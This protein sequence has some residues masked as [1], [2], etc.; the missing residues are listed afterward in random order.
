MT[1]LH[2]IYRAL[3]FA[4][5]VPAAGSAVSAQTTGSLTEIL[6]GN[7]GPSASEWPLYIAEQKGF[8][9]EQGLKVTII[10][11]GSSTNVANAVVTG[12]VNIATDGADAIVAAV[13]HGLTT[14]IIAPAF[15]TMPYQLIAIPSIT[16]WAQ[17]KGKSIAVGPK[18]GGVAAMAFYSMIAAQH[19]KDSDFELTGG[20][21]SGAR[22][23]ALMSGNV[24]AALLS[25]P[26][27]ILAQSQGM[28]TLAD[29]SE[30]FKNW[31]STAVA[32]NTTWAENNRGVILRFLRAERKAIAYGYANRAGTV[33][34]LVA[35][36]IDQQVAQK[37]Y[38]L[39]FGR[40]RAFDPSMRLSTAALQ[41]VA[42]VMVGQGSLTSIP[43][44]NDMFDPSY[45]AE[46][47]R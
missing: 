27:D 4:A 24:Q 35:L 17:L 8:F 1:K 12:A 23:A 39:D 26:F 18:Q 42:N 34:V 10:A 9:Q 5:L 28:K 16:T 31:I 25:Q 44:I 2:Q 47:F 46:A 15:T 6:Y 13:A 40:W 32:V 22:Y 36:R 37:A 29:G 20:G 41:N 30:Y 45:V 33:A 3:V 43:S 19:L 7:L 14:R 38:D 11:G 21:S